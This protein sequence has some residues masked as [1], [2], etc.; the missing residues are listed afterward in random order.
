MEN[1]LYKSMSEPQYEEAKEF[2]TRNYQIKQN[3]INERYYD[4][5]EKLNIEIV[6]ARLQTNN[7]NVSTAAI[8]SILYL[9]TLHLDHQYNPAWDYFDS[10]KHIK[11]P[12][13]PDTWGYYLTQMNI[14]PTP[15][16]VKRFKYMIESVCFRLCDVSVYKSIFVFLDLSNKPQVCFGDFF[17]ALV[18]PQYTCD[19][20]RKDR[21]S[22]FESMANYPVEDAIKETY[23]GKM[24]IH[25]DESRLEYDDYQRFMIDMRRTGAYCI[26]TNNAELVKKIKSKRP[27]DVNY[28]IITV[29]NVINLDNIDKFREQMW[30]EAYRKFIKSFENS[31]RKHIKWV[32]S[33]TAHNY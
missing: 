6:Q 30:A 23:L 7:I 15:L 9:Q 21:H 10:I 27:H 12:R 1:D 26:G 33:V 3:L 29:D 22:G 16:N 5:N 2:I 25:C 19:F 20:T 4:N 32:E 11:K 17:N 8:E 14:E 13:L 28:V 24:I 31:M 18:P